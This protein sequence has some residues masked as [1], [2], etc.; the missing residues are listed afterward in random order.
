MDNT[1]QKQLKEVIDRFGD[2][3]KDSSR[4]SEGRMSMNLHPYERLFEPIQINGI[5]IK[6]RIAMGPMGNASMADETGRPGNK[7]IQYFIE[8]A[9]GGAGLITSGMTPVSL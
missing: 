8:R 2:W 5:K 9:K 4:L 1:Y 6:N 3:F 7:M